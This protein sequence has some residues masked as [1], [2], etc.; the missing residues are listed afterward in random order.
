M[1]TCLVADSDAAGRFRFEVPA[2]SAVAM[3]THESKSPRWA[4]ALE[5]IAVAGERVDLGELYVPDLPA[6]SL[7]G[8]ESANPQT[9]DAGDG[10]TLTLSFGDLKPDVGVFLFDLAARKLPDEYVPVYPTI[11]DETV[12]AVYALHPFNTTSSSPIAVRAPA[13]LAGGTAV[14]FRTVSVFDG[15]LS[16]PVTGKSDGAFVTTD[17][18]KGITAL[19]YLVISAP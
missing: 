12:V 6:G 15:A 8:P 17:A 9:L 16:A 7:F 5:P 14:N 10:L 19:T 1:I 18:G 13:A 3:K 4:A 11:P 2:G